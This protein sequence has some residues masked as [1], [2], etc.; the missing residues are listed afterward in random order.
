MQLCSVHLWILSLIVQFIVERLL[1]DIFFS[2]LFSNRAVN[3]RFSRLE[4][5]V[6]TLARSVAHL[7]SELR[8]QASISQDMD[9]MRRQVN[10]QQY[11]PEEDSDPAKESAMLQSRVKKL[12]RCVLIIELQTSHSILGSY[13]DVALGR[14][15]FCSR[16]VVA[17]R[18]EITFKLVVC[19][20]CFDYSSHDVSSGG[21]K[22]TKTEKL[23]RNK[24]ER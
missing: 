15:A 9:D 12:R 2:L 24:N 14:H 11:K 3:K 1:H 13:E 4:S 18:A 16:G 10:A 17:W 7:S 23:N 5:H 20:E 8:S 6:V 22:T 19:N 21:E